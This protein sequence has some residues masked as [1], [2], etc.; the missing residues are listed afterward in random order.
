MLI[1]V[2]RLD[3]REGLDETRIFTDEGNYVWSK[4][5]GRRQW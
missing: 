2:T 5:R 4:Q 1:N 3:K